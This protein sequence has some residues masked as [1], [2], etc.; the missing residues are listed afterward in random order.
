MPQPYSGQ[1]FLLPF[2][3]PGGIERVFRDTPSMISGTVQ[4]SPMKLY[5]VI[6]LLKTYQNTKRN[7]L[8]S[9]V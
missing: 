7:F 6:V 2:K 9:Y 5:T 8:K 4:A 1:A 3:G